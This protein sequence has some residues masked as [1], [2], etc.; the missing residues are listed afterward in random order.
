MSRTSCT[1]FVIPILGMEKY[2]WLIQGKAILST[3]TFYTCFVITSLG[4]QIT[5]DSRHRDSIHLYTGTYVYIITLA[6]QWNSSSMDF[7]L[8]LYYISYM[9]PWFLY[10][11]DNPSETEATQQTVLNF[12]HDKVVNSTT[13]VQCK[14]PYVW[15]DTVQG[16]H[17]T[18]WSR[19][20]ALL[21]GQFD[22]GTAVQGLPKKS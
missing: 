8:Q 20:L 5:V 15:I 14:P 2:R 13:S 4:M 11:S 17:S 1:C 19:W 16:H 22:L 3:R 18:V 12:L 9:I 21:Y 10:S 7:L 6:V